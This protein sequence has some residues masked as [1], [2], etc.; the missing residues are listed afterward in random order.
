MNY[1]IGCDVGSQS[2]RATLVSFEGRVVGEA[3]DGYGIDFPRPLWAEQPV[4]RWIEALTTAIRR[5]MAETGTS[6]QDVKAIALAT[7]VD[8][9]VAVDA[10]G[11]V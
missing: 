6:P 9:V 8:G 11:N 4:E 7:Q 1:V 3:S 5:V 10:T 2:T